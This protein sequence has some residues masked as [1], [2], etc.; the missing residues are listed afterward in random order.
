MLTND[1]LSATNADKS[2]G[3]L[4]RFRA[5]DRASLNRPSV[6]DGGARNGGGDGGV[7]GGGGGGGHGW[8]AP[9]TVPRFDVDSM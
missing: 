4:A 8:T 7:R 1:E 6:G 2:R 5:D 3:N 9:A